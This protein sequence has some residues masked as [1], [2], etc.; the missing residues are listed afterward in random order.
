MATRVAKLR[1]KI[2]KGRK[3]LAEVYGAPLYG[4]KTGLNQAFIIDTTIHD[5]GGRLHRG[6]AG[7]S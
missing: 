3:T 2:T 4:I 1:S 7:L 5:H 6:G